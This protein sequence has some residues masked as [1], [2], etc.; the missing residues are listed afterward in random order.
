MNALD[1]RPHGFDIHRLRQMVIKASLRCAVLVPR[2][3]P[4]GDRNEPQ[5]FGGP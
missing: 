1:D 4:A 2:L 5:V 3:A